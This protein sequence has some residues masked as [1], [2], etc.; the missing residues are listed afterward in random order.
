MSE[1]TLPYTHSA[2]ATRCGANHAQNEDRYRILDAAHPAVAAMRRGSLYVVCDGVSSTPRGLWAA[3]LTCSRMDG[4]YD[5]KVA[6]RESSLLQ[7]LSEIDW[8]LR[9]LGPGEAACTLSCLWLADQVATVLHVGD[10]QVYRVRHGRAMRITA[11]HRTGRALGAYLGMGPAISEAVQVWQEPLFVGDLFLLVTDGVTE[12]L[13]PDSLL[14]V[15]W[16]HGGSPRRAATAI[17][18]EVDAKKGTDDATAIVVDVLALET[19]GDDEST[20]TARTEFKRPRR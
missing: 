19:D 16:A 18:Q 8:E 2:A 13:P 7:S 20:V 6:P 14:D 17:I 1:G 9:E 15:W 3:D 12:V 11:D 4:F 10:S 5:H